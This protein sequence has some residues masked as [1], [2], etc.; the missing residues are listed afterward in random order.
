VKRGNLLK[1]KQRKK[2][3]KNQEKK[4]VVN[5]E[6]LIFALRFKKKR[7]SSS[8]TSRIAQKKNLRKF[9]KKFGEMIKVLNF[10]TPIKNGVRKTN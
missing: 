1:K 7:K 2:K 9:K 4:L 3:K 5:V 10:A 6:P 8:N